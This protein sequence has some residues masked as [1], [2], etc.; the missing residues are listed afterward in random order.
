LLAKI[1]DE[2]K[3]P[4]TFFHLNYHKVKYIQHIK[5]FVNVD[6][7]ITKTLLRTLKN[8]GR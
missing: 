2:E 4:S 7:S 8:F 1:N 5:R 3:K 6:L